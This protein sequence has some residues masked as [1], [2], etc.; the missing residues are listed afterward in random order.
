MKRLK[1]FCEKLSLFSCRFVRLL[2][3]GLT[4]F[5][6]L[7]AFFFTCYSENMETQQVLT[8]WDNPLSSLLGLAVLSAT[9]L[10][11]L[12]AIRLLQRLFPALRAGRLLLFLV[13]A[14]CL[15]VGAALILF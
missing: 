6:F 10:G 13:M 4:G 11:V 3:L 7:G 9:V 1:L 15:F 12:G 8:K 5:L 2:A 14:W